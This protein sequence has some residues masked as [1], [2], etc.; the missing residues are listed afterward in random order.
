M[1]LNLVSN[2]IK[3][4]KKGGTVSIICKIVRS[5]AELAFKSLEFEALEWDNQ[6]MLEMQI[7]D[8]GVGISQED[9]KKLFKL[10]GFLDATKEINT[11]GIGL[12]LHISKMICQQFGGSIVCRSEIGKGT[13]FIF[14]FPTSELESEIKAGSRHV[15]PNPLSRHYK[16]IK[17][18]T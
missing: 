9:Q 13:N 5:F 18:L 3:F 2:A 15:N 4:T 11:K 8:T 16:K 6:A 12:G 17:I 7:D 1:L 14:L 10:F